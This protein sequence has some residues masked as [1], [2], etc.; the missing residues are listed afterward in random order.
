MK[1]RRYLYCKSKWHERGL[2]RPCRKCRWACRAA[3]LSIWHLI[4]AIESGWGARGHFHRVKGK[5][6]FLDKNSVRR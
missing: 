3:G 5:W 6:V 1:T 2:H 4:L